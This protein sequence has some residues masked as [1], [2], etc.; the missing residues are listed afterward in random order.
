MDDPKNSFIKISIG[1]HNERI[2]S[3]HLADHFFQVSLS[4]MSDTAEL[5]DGGTNLSRAGKRDEIDVRMNYEV[6]ADRFS[7]STN[8]IGHPWRYPGLFQG[9]HKESANH[10][11][12]FRWLNHHRIAGDQCRHRH[13]TKNRQR[14]IPR[15]ND[16]A[17]ASRDVIFN[18]DFAGDI[19]SQ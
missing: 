14:K 17:D 12:L 2:L 4:G 19:L 1:I 11:G 3:A 6:R 16:G 15:R 13:P 10:G 5:P 18:T 9:L 7:R 8:Q